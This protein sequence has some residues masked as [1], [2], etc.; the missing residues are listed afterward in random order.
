MD[1]PKV[2]C[3]KRKNGK[4]VQDSDIYIGRRMTM[5]GWN[6]PESKWANPYGLKDYSLSDSLN[7]YEKKIRNDSELM[8]AISD[9]TGKVLGCWCKGKRADDRCHGDILV[10]IWKESQENKKISTHQMRSKHRAIVSYNGYSKD[11]LISAVQKYIRR[12]SLDKALWCAIELDLFR[13]LELDENGFRAAY[14]AKYPDA[15]LKTETSAAKATRTNLINRLR[16]ICF[17][18]IGM[19]APWMPIALDRLIRQWE[20]GRRSKRALLESVILLCKAPKIRLVSDVRTLYLLPPYYGKTTKANQKILGILNSLLDEQ[21]L[22]ILRVSEST[23]GLSGYK[24][25]FQRCLRKKDINVF[26]WVSMYYREHQSLDIVWQWM[27]RIDVPDWI[28]ETLVILKNWYDKM[29]HKDRTGYL[30]Q[31]ILIVLYRDRIDQS[32]PDLEL[33]DKDIEQ[34]YQTNLSLEKIELDDFCV[35]IHT[36][37][38]KHRNSKDG[39][40]LGKFATEG[41]HVENECL[42]FFNPVYRTIYNEL[43]I[44]MD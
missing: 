43:K 31:A 11:V 17:E 22:D 33:S 9:L 10:K 44:R 39:G 16:V 28:T 13:L 30:Y 36:Q 1:I 26:Y 32:S 37:S 25:N 27:K 40:G 5:G 8:N 21:G 4:I 35:D 20:S 38:G 12:G 34:R 3:L 41:A 29:T 42:E 24:K 15:N 6:L 14:Q 7:K 2:V 23:D 18:D 19:G